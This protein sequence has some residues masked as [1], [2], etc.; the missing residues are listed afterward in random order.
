MRH[1]VGCS[2]PLTVF[3]RSFIVPPYGPITG[4]TN[5][6]V[7]GDFEAGTRYDCYFGQLRVPSQ[8]LNNNGSAIVQLACI[9]PLSLSPGPVRFALRETA[10][11]AH[12]AVRSPAGDRRRDLP[13]PLSDVTFTYYEKPVPMHMTPERGPM[14]GG[15][16]LNI[17]GFG[18]CVVCI[19]RS[20]VCS[21]C[22]VRTRAR[23]WRVSLAIT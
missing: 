23:L 8:P 20:T 17:T 13:S 9:S 11:G 18:L 19:G 15:Y 1:R 4:D 21:S 22:I 2:W 3:F 16:T 6:T 14:R 5:V 10:S 12:I 7:T